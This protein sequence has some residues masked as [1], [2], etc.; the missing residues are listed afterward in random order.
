MASSRV[1]GLAPYPCCLDP[2]SRSSLREQGYVHLRQF[3][4][5]HKWKPCIR[6]ADGAVDHA[7]CQWPL[8]RDAMARLASRTGWRKPALSKYRVSAGT[9]LG[10]SNAT[11]AAA[12]H[13]DLFIYGEEVVPAIFTMILYLDPAELRVVPGSHRKPH[14]NWYESFT[15]LGAAS[16]LRFEP[17]DA[18]LFHATLLHG[19]VFASGR[20]QDTVASPRRII[21]LFDIYPRSKQAHVDH[22]S[23]RVLH[24]R[25]PKKDENNG[26]RVSSFMH[27]E[28]LAPILLWL[29]T[30]SGASGYG[31]RAHFRPPAPF[32]MI[33]GEAYRSRTCRSQQGWL[34]GNTYVLVGEGCAVHDADTSNNDKIRK[35]LYRDMQ[36]NMISTHLGIPLL[37][38]T[39]ILVIATIA[40]Q[41][42][43]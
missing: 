15:V 40:T 42:H 13:R 12:V 9:T 23:D 32:S 37:T 21:Q 30:I 36:I 35:W 11:D 7:N 25:S 18:L 8:V 38:V 33:S 4:D 31:Y 28:A 17:G 43:G 14:M 2:A 22:D 10:T 39:A 29:F 16:K 34:Q 24:I 19:G 26:L 5:C 6:L 20:Q 41:K 3:I 1:M 27:S